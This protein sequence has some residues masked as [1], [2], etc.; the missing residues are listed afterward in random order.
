MSQRSLP[1]KA[2]KRLFI[3]RV[4]SFALLVCRAKLHQEV[5]KWLMNQGK[6]LEIT[7]LAANWT[8]C[9]AWTLCQDR[10]PF[11][12]SAWPGL[13]CSRSYDWTKQNLDISLKLWFPQ[14]PSSWTHCSDTVQH[15][16]KGQNSREYLG[17]NQTAQ[18][19]IYWHCLS[20]TIC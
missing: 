9:S 3:T 19:R 8:L 1:E 13:T 15:L 6:I 20:W 14:Q 18:N 4:L 16:R 17:L 7:G 5:H 12:V 2:L 11:P 10:L